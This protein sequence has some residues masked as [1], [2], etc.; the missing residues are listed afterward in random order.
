M[1]WIWVVAAI[2]AWMAF[3]WLAGGAIALPMLAA[4]HALD[5]WRRSRTAERRP[6]HG[7]DPA[8]TATAVLA[9]TSLA[10]YA[11]YRPD[12]LVAAGLVVAT[13][14]RLLSPR[15]QLS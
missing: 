13:A 9:A 3:A 6:W 2:L 1:R 7:A 10:V 15:R 8:H 11:G 14:I 12:W 4:M 5:G